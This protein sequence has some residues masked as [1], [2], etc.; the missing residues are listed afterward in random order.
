MG[1]DGLGNSL[2][3]LHFL[4]E[5]LLERPSASQLLCV[6]DNLLLLSALL[7]A[8]L[9]QGSAVG[10]GSVDDPS[11]CKVMQHDGFLMSSLK[12]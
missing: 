4:P 9:A 6:K 10:P 12:T 1:R 8:H 2:L 5:E 7:L 3:L 11:G